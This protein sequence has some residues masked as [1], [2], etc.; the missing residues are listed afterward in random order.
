MTLQKKLLKVFNIDELKTLCVDLGID[1]ERIPHGTKDEFCRELI[2]YVQRR[3]NLAELV[4]RCKQ[5]RPQ[6]AWEDTLDIS[7]A[8]PTEDRVA[9]A[10]FAPNPFGLS[11][12]IINLADFFDREELLRRIFEALR[13]GSNL[14]LVGES[15]VGKSSILSMICQMGPEQLGMPS[16]AFV[17]LDMQFIHDENDFFDA[18]CDKVAVPECRGYRLERALRGKRF[19]LCID[20]IE[21]MADTR[22]FTGEERTELRGFADGADSPLM[23]V[24]ASRLPLSNVFPDSPGMTSPLAGICAPV[25]VPPF[26][27]EVA[28]RFIQSRLQGTG[29]TFTDSEIDDL[30]AHTGGHPGR[31]QW[32]AA[33]LYMRHALT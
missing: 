7:G 27:P 3:N 13:K 20:E 21:K 2:L 9:I 28:R 19:V 17:Y 6:V 12:R 30:V 22:H 5:L 29:V 8:D 16:V 15:Q 1:Y 10:K 33:D 26:T 32:A 11:G 23:L 14:S 24:I 31:L 18:L 4:S 25:D